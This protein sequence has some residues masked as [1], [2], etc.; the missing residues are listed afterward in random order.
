MVSQWVIDTTIKMITDKLAVIAP[1]NQAMLPFTMS[2][3][4]NL[5]H[6]DIMVKRDHTEYDIHS[7][8]EE[9]ILALK[10]AY[11]RMGNWQSLEKSAPRY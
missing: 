11:K 3:E 6:V 2:L 7:E 4:G 10:G 5:W 9:L 8:N 1:D